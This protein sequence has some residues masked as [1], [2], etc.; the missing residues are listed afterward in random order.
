MKHHGLLDLHR[1]EVC[2]AWLRGPVRNV[3]VAAQPRHQ[4]TRDFRDWNRS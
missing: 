1:A 4:V 2:L 3:Q